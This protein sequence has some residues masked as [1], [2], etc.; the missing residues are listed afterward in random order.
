LGW[1]IKSYQWIFLFVLTFSIVFNTACYKFK[2]D[3]TIPAY[4]KIDSVFVDTYYPKEGSNSSK[5]SDVWIYVNDN[6][7]G[8][9]ELPAILPVLAQG[10]QK[11]DIRAGIKL[12]GISSTRVPYPFY[13]PI[14]FE[15]FNFIP[16]STITISKPVSTYYSNLVFAWMEDFEGSSISLE[17]NTASDTTIQKTAPKNNPEAF[18]SE[19]SQYS[20]VVYLTEERPIFSAATYGTFDMPNQGSPVALEMNFKSNN[21]LNVGLLVIE[22]N[23]YVKI[24]LLILNHSEDWNKIY[25]NLGPNLSLHPQAAGFKVYFEAGLDTDKTS[26]TIYLDNL[27]VIHRP[28]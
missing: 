1:N 26:S 18:L 15:D 6:I 27:K 13:E 7:V 11:L 5:I 21:Y 3:Q 22:S 4:L 14:L 20:G 17:A 8:V 2:G 16:D 24:P 25:I 10:E 28:I 9:Y 23:S 12:N 19:H